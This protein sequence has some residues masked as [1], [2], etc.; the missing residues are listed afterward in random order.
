MKLK[1]DTKKIEK[2]QERG[3]RIVFQDTVSN[4]QDL[5][6]KA[7]LKNQE[8]NRIQ[9]I[10]VEVFKALKGQTPVY[11]KELFVEK[12][13][14]YDL[15]RKDQLTLYHHR[16]KAYGIQTFSHQGARMWNK[17]DNSYK[18]CETAKDFKN[19]L[20]NFNVVTL[21]SNF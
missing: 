13:T 3:L 12:D 17:L 15:V 20:S 14:S 6:D 8:E 19:G 7:N 18:N 21:R 5:L 4:Y 16:T 1:T 2:I 10:L 11:I 9:G